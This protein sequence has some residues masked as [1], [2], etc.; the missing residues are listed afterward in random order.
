[1]V[2][3]ESDLRKKLFARNALRCAALRVLC[4]GCA[5]S[6]TA[7]HRQ[8]IFFGRHAHCILDFCCRHCFL[9]QGPGYHGDRTVARDLFN[10]TRCA[11]LHVYC[12]QDDALGGQ[13]RYSN[14]LDCR[15][16]SILVFVA[17]RFVFSRRTGCHEMNSMHAVICSPRR[18][19]YVYCAQVRELD[20]RWSNILPARHARPAS[21]VLFAPTASLRGTGYHSRLRPSHEF[22]CLPRAALHVY[23]AQD[24]LN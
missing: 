23:C 13:L 22:I 11:A 8:Q 10:A 17:R 21:L 14:I 5:E 1:M 2:S 7:S 12:A 24:A 15:S 6:K 9:P 20:M 3:R 19:R 16:P 4:T 18:L